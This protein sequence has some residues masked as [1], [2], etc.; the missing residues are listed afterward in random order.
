MNKH[1]ATILAAFALVSGT[2]NAQSLKSLFKELANNLSERVE[3]AVTEP[4]NAQEPS[5]QVDTIDYSQRGTWFLETIDGRHFQVK[6]FRVSG[7]ASNGMSLADLLS[8]AEAASFTKI[9]ESRFSKT[10]RVRLEYR[11]I[12]GGGTSLTSNLI[13]GAL[14]RTF[15][16]SMPNDIEVVIFTIDGSSLGGSTWCLSVPSSTLRSLRYVK[17]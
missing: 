8:M 3:Q 16:K 10:Y 14:N 15:Q 11:N 12:G 2:A 6:D 17:E 5:A 9:E 7:S 13:S 4:C 1:V